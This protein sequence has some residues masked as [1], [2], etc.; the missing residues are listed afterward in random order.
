GEPVVTRYTFGIEENNVLNFGTL[1]E[2]LLDLVVLL[3]VGENEDARAR[4]VENVAHLRRRQRRINRN[5][6]RAREDRTG[7]RQ[8]PFN[9]TLGKQ[10]DAIAMTRPNRVQPGG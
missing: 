4:V 1:A 9:A 7:V 6:D 8:R 3:P 2:C 5:V 10:S